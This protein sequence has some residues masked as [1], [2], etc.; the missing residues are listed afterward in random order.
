MKTSRAFTTVAA[1]IA[2]L[3]T[4]ANAAHAQ[5]YVQ[6]CVIGDP[7]NCDKTTSSV[8]NG[9]AIWGSATGTGTTYG[10]FGSGTEG[11]RGLATVASGI[12]VHGFA[13]AAGGATTGVIGETNSST[14]V[15]VRAL[16][17]DSFAFVAENNSH[18][19]QTVW[20]ENDDHSGTALYVAYGKTVIGATLEF[21]GPVMPYAPNV[22]NLGSLSNYFLNVFSKNYTTISSDARLKKDI[23]DTTYGL[24]TLLKLRPVTFRWKEGSDDTQQL[25]LIA[26]EVER[27][28]PE[29]VVHGKEPSDPLMMK[30]EALVPVLIKAVQEQQARIGKLEKE[31]SPV[32]SSFFS[33]GFGE[34]A[35]LGLLP[36]GWILGRRRRRMMVNT[37]RAKF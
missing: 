18:S 29:I 28:I 31:R 33:G 8:A 14:G 30:Y 9:T 25:G 36:L 2:G 5:K 10:V 15:G 12:G 24:E 1:S 7:S 11:V 23:R 37:E 13:A 34:G 6:T 21:Q 17:G 22:I 32:M 3:L 4:I 20:I 35:A 19:S 16:A 26:Q 27:V